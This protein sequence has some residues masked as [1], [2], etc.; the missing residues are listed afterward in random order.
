[1]T[2]PTIPPRIRL[3][4]LQRQSPQRLSIVFR[5]VTPFLLRF[6]PLSVGI[7]FICNVLLSIRRRGSITYTHNSVEV[8]FL[9]IDPEQPN[10]L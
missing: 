3:P 1:M 7:I 2:L 10:S 8:I 9:S 5:I 4:L 6:L